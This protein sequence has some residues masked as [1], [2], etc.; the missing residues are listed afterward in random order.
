MDIK[1]QLTAEQFKAIFNGPFAAAAF[2]STASGGGFEMVSELLSAGKFVG[3]QLKSADESG[4]GELVDGLLTD[5]RTMPKEEAKAATIQYQGKDPIALRAQARQAV[6]EAGAVVA[7][8][9]GADGYK[10]WILD[11]ARTVAATKTGGFLGI[12]A[13]SVV[14]EQEQ[15][16]LDE[17]AAALELSGQ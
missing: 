13:K 3:A 17:L 2:V 6:V 9:A 4:Y 1:D 15:A 14:D 11:I 5:L 16:A 10:K 12:G 7:G 8:M